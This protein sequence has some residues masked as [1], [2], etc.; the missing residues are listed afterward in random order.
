MNDYRDTNRVEN[1][2]EYERGDCVVHSMPQLVF[3]EL[4]RDCNLRCPMCKPS[5][6]FGTGRRPELD[7]TARIFSAVAEQLFNTAVVVDLRGVGESAILDTL[8]ERVRL[9]DK[10]GA[11]VRLVTNLSYKTDDLLRVLV[12]CNTLLAFSLDAVDKKLY[13]QLRKNGQFELVLRNLVLL[14]E[15]RVASGTCKDMT[16]NIVLQRSNLS[17]VHSIMEFIS[18][19]G[20]RRICIWPMFSWHS[21]TRP[22]SGLGSLVVDLIGGYL[23]HAT[24]LGIELRVTD[25]PVEKREDKRVLHF[26]RCIRPWMYTYVNYDGTIGQCDTL[27]DALERRQPT[28]RNTAFMKIWNSENYCAL[29]R[30]HMSRQNCGVDAYAFCSRVCFPCRFVEIEDLFYPRCAARIFSNRFPDSADG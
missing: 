18:S 22:L 6:I 20:V 2:K 21:G 30:S 8:P 25:W 23:E 9:V 29:R 27:P 1:I 26:H 24:K 7:M 10:C 14:S 19:Y 12:E 5:K 15:M 11:R 13:S 28:L 3:V 4:T 17:Q 16:C